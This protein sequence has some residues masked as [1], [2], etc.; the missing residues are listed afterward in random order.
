MTWTQA[1]ILGLVQGLTEFLPV[2]SS[3]HLVIFNHLFGEYGG[4]DLTFSVFLHFATLVSVFIMF[5]R[6]I[7]LLVREFFKLLGDIFRGKFHFHTPER[8]FLLMVIL[9]TIPAGLAGLVISALNFTHVLENIFVAAAFLLVTAALMLSVDKL[10]AKRAQFDQSNA[11]YKSAWIVG[12]MQAV[13]IFPGLSRSGST[14]FGGAVAGLQK[15]FAVRYAF[16]LSIPA[17]LGAGL[18]E[19]VA[20]VQHGI[21]FHAL[22]WL[23]GFVAAAVSG[24]LAI[25]IIKLLIRKRK[26]YLFGFY[27]LAAAIAAFVIGLSI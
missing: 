17:I 12:V 19:A 23:V 9:G 27:C 14:I 25:S 8:R 15:D 16:I 5:W 7:A 1:L 10:F 21:D 13:A 6:D 22:N 3:G 24:V 4:G 20:A 18:L 11:P 2:S 26:F